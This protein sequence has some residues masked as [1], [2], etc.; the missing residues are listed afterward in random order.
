M[1]I[2]LGNGL[3]RLKPLRADLEDVTLRGQGKLN[4]LTDKFEADFAARLSPEL[5]E[6]DPACA[7]NQRY[8]AIDWPVSCEGDITGDPADWCGV[9]SGKIIE[10]LATNEV[11]RKVQKEGVKLLEG[12]LS[13]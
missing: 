6:L 5:A 9:D 2:Q 4:L 1:D 7:I 8:T 3:A 10:E 11:K 13:R 12:L